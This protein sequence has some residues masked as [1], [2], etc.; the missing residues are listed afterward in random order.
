L[1]AAFSRVSKI[2]GNAIRS[3]R[4]LSD[5]LLPPA[6]APVVKNLLLSNR[7]EF[8]SACAAVLAVRNELAVARGLRG[9]VDIGGIVGTTAH[10]VALVLAKEIDERITIAV[11]GA[12]R[13]VGAFD[14]S[15]LGNLLGSTGTENALELNLLV[16]HFDAVGQQFSTDGL[17][18]NDQAIQ[19]EI[20][21]EAR[22]AAQA[23]ACRLSSAP[24][25]VT[26]DKVV[27]TDLLLSWPEILKALNRTSASKEAIR[28]LNKDYEGPILFMGRGSQPKA[29][30]VALVNWWNGL[31]NA[32]ESCQAAD[33]QQEVDRNATAA[34]QY[35]H[36]KDG[37]ADTEV[38][39]IAGR[40]KGRRR[41]S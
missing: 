41:S 1:F 26:G 20:E 27:P 13:V 3:A 30:R 12:L 37:H 28:K 35:R 2:A 38:P 17:P 10:E 15:V 14:P 4:W 40:V 36:G 5:R 22:M 19:A 21:I 16:K 8:D 24:T 23:R 39:D 7:A 34:N 32:F 33:A 9:P 18:D 11:V 31:R 29:D 6:I 25:P